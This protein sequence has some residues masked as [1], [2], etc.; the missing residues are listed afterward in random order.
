MSTAR[1]RHQRPKV[2]N[3]VVNQDGEVVYRCVSKPE[4]MRVFDT[5]CRLRPD[6]SFSLVQC[7]AVYRS[8]TLDRPDHAAVDLTD[9]GTEEYML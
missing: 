5:V 8:P 9:L 6:M 7:L 4:A 2:Y 3:E 1:Q